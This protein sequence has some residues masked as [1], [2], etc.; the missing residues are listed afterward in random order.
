MSNKKTAAVAAAAAESEVDVTVNNVDV[1]TKYTTAAD[2]SNQV[3]KKVIA[4]VVDGARVLDICIL[5]DKAIEEGTKGVYNKDKTQK[6]I[7]FPTC[8]SVN[9]IICNFSPL[10]SDPEAASVIKTGDMVKIQ[11][12]AQIDGFAAIVAHTVVVGAS[13]ENPIKGRKADVLQAAHLALEAAIRLVKPGAKN[14]DVT[15]VITQIAD[16][17]EVKPVEGQISFNQERNV[18]DGKKQIIQAPSEQQLHDFERVEFAENEVYAVDILITSSAE[19]KPKP[20]AA[21]TSV[22]KKTDTRYELKMKTSRAVLKELNTKFGQF[23]FPLRDLE[24]E[25][26]ARMGILECAK[27]HLVL[28]YEVLYDKED[29]F[30]AQFLA[31]ILLTK[32]GTLKVTSPPFDQSIVQSDKS[33]KNETLIALLATSL[34]PKK[35]KKKAVEGEAEKKEE[36]AK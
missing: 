36:E 3:L 18:I 14:M 9:N 22:Y 1:V 33:L 19:G 20:G 2:I 28:P 7:G 35:N 32:N 23:P 6:G 8:I 4:A 10:P 17:F 27:H 13:A 12:G 26:K 29:A 16:A 5:G 21:R 31:T 34:K 25:K 24:D 11:L 30:V 15:K